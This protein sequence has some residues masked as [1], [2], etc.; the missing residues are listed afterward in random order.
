MTLPDIHRQK[1]ISGRHLKNAVCHWLFLG[2]TLIAILALLILLVRIFHQGAGWLTRD[3]L[4][5]F[6]SRFPNQAGIKSALFGSMW[7]LGITAPI[8]FTVGVGAAIYLEEYA[9]RTWFSKLITVNIANLAGVPSIVYGILGL[10]IFVRALDLGRSV[11]AG[12][13][14]MALLIL[15][16]V[17]VA[18]REAIR[19]VPDYLRH[20]AYALGATRWQVLRTVV[21]PSALPGILTGTVLALSRAIGESAPMIMIGALAFV[22]FI[23]QSALDPFTVLPIQIYSWTSRPQEEFQH[24]AAAGII[25]LLAVLLVM[26]GG[27]VLL[28]NKFRKKL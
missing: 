13:L 25:V 14:T 26:N 10:A 21:I 24:V 2:A 8:S 18:S 17:V 3:F 16:I 28:R 6:P 9:K 20:A 1:K 15:P 23:P 27:A 19:S 11:L 12:S 22:A 4:T 7:L 5:S